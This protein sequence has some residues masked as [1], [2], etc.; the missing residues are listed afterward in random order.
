MP[1]ENCQ[2]VRRKTVKNRLQNRK[3]QAHFFISRRETFISRREI[4]IPKREM[5]ISRR[6]IKN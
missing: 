4:L 1:T 2:K 3:E 5:T 6:E